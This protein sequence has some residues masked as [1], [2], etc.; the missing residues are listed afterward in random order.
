MRSCTRSSCSAN[1]FRA[2]SSDLRRHLA[3]L[4][5]HH[6]DAISQNAVIYQPRRLRRLRLHRLIERI[7]NSFRY[8]VTDFG[9]RVA[10]FFTRT[11][12]SLLRPGF[13]AAL[14]HSSTI[15]NGVTRAFNQIA[16]R[17]A[18]M[19]ENARLAKA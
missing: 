16:S 8:Q 13:A 5:G 9:F 6:P 3:N 7:P 14:A 15:D 12:N 18:S 17:I 2:A 19:I 11:Y 10:L 1:S 4:Q